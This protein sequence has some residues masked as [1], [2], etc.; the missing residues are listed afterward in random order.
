MIETIAFHIAAGSLGG[1][2]A[3]GLLKQLNLG[4]GG[5][6]LCGLAG[7]ALAAG[8]GA[9]AGTLATSGGLP[10]LVIGGCGG[11]TLMA[12]A[13]LLREIRGSG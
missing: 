11:A 3:G 2:L 4:L 12:L 7:G 5:N 13:G 6:T 8:A 1:N 9:V 10:A